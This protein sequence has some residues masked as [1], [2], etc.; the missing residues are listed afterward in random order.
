MLTDLAEPETTIVAM[1]SPPPPPPPPP[2]ADRD[3]EQALVARAQRGDVAAFVPSFD[4]V[5]FLRYDDC[6]A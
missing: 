2:P 1:P 4:T 5:S 3:A 6:L